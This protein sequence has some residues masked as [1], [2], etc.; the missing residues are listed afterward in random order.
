VLNAP[1]SYKVQRSSGTYKR[2]RRHLRQT[3]KSFLPATFTQSRV[4]DEDDAH[5][6]S[7]T[8]KLT[9]PNAD[10]GE[11]QN[12][13]VTDYGGVPP[14]ALLLYFAPPR[15]SPSS[16]LLP[17][18]TEAGE[19]LG[20]TASNWGHGAAEVPSTYSSVCPAF[21]S[22]APIGSRS[23]VGTIVQRDED[24]VNYT[25]GT[26]LSGRRLLLVFALTKLNFDKG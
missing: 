2:N 9:T 13:T 22:A 18:S 20:L 19:V 4:D 3:R 11:P 16:S 21:I 1:R 26:S 7:P 10:P 23:G 8:A 15:P 24:F 25:A 5:A 12:D 6:T 14:P 17:S